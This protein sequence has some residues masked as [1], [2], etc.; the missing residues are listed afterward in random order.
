MKKKE[1]HGRQNTG[2][3][4]LRIFFETF[5]AK[6]LV[7]VQA[8]GICPILAVGTHLKYGVALTVCTAAVLLPTSLF[9]SYCGERLPA[10]SRPPLYTV[11]ASVLL[12]G[13]ALVVD[14]F[15]SHE[16]YAALYLFLPLMAVNTIFTYRAGG[17]SVTNRPLA[18]LVDAVGSSL[19]FGLVI[20]VVSALRELAIAGTIWD[21]PLNTPFRL[22]EAALSFAGFLLLGFLAAFVQ[23]LKAFV[24]RLAGEKEESV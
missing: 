12:V 13:A 17:F 16:I 19:G 6:N 23:W 9:M 14:Q 18:A 15:I 3:E 2:R 8:I 22:P 5:L 10:W 20:C 7:L 24:R 21:V 4:L 11:G 1:Y